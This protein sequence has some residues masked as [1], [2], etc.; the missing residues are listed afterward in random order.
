MC[1][2]DEV[3][4]KRDKSGGSKGEKMA[5][6]K[7]C[8]LTLAVAALGTGIVVAFAISVVAIIDFQDSGAFKYHPICMS[9]AFLGFMV[10]GLL[11]YWGQIPPAAGVAGTRGAVQKSNR[12]ALHVVMMAVA[13]IASLLGYV[14]IFIAHW[15]KSHFASGK[16]FLRQV[17]VWLGYVVLLLVATQISVGISKFY[18][19]PEKILRWHGKLGIAVFCGGLLNIFIASMFW[20]SSIFSLPVSITTCFLLSAVLGLVLYVRHDTMQRR[21]E[22]DGFSPI[23]VAR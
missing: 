16:P 21:H 4:A 5:P 13:G 12:R 1:E 15:G 22:L 10:T 19:L 23:P 17:H 11:A 14:A 8:A 2:I 6:P 20:R 3:T 9:L 7:P 18:N